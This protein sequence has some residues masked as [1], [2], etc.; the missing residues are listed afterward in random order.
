MNEAML[1]L[2]TDDFMVCTEQNT[3]T[4]T[5]IPLILYIYVSTQLFMEKYKDRFGLHLDLDSY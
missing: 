1:L 2:L 3:N 4:F 5:S